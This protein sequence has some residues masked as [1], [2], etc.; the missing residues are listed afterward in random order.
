MSEY[1]P[2]LSKKYSLLDSPKVR[3]LYR[4]IEKAFYFTGEGKQAYNE[5]Y[6]QNAH[7]YTRWEYFF[8]PNQ[9]DKRRNLEVISLDTDDTD[10]AAFAIGPFQTGEEDNILMALSLSLGSRKQQIDYGHYNIGNYG[11]ILTPAAWLTIAGRP[12]EKYIAFTPIGILRSSTEWLA[13]PYEDIGSISIAIATSKSPIDLISFDKNS[14]KD[15]IT[16]GAPIEVSKLVD[17]PFGNSNP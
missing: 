13:A 9:M 6:V 1:L 4:S 17:S 2:T 5:K 16:R 12:D 3:I 8:D 15:V 7:F 10:Q 11:E 14:L